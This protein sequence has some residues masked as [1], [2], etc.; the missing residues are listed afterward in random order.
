[1]APRSRQASVKRTRP[2]GHEPPT[3]T[4]HVPMQFRRRNGRK[5][6]AAYH[7][8]QKRQTGDSRPDPVV[9]ALARA[10]YWRRLIEAGAYASMAEIASAEGV[11]GSYVSRLLRLSLLAP[12]IVTVILDPDTRSAFLSLDALTR[13]VPVEWK[14]QNLRYL[15]RPLWAN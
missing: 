2:V 9:A 7:D 14:S 15:T 10:F 12:K 8:D 11:S 6:F 3:V 5:A 4:V 13:P 1:M